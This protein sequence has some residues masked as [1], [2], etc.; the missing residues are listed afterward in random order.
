MERL[1]FDPISGYRPKQPHDPWFGIEQEYFVTR[2]D[3][4]PVSYDQKKI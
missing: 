3:G 1:N 4:V 2:D